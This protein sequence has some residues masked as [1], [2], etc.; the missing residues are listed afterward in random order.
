METL[1]SSSYDDP[2]PTAFCVCAF[3]SSSVFF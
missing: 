2:G 3:A 1:I